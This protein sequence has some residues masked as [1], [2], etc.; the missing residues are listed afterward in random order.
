MDIFDYEPELKYDFI[1]MGEIIE[2]LEN[3]KELLLKMKNLLTDNGLC[4][5]TIPINS[6]AIDHI[7]IFRDQHE[8][9]TMICN[10]G[11]KIIGDFVAPEYTGSPSNHKNLPHSYWAVVSK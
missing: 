8:I 6:P 5:K 3:P 10:A 9:R 4:F 11:L 2:H 7:Y 1:T